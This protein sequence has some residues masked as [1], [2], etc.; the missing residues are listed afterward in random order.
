MFASQSGSALFTAGL[1]VYLNLPLLQVSQMLLSSVTG[2]ALVESVSLTEDTDTH[3][4]SSGLYVCLV[5][6]MYYCYGTC[7][8]II[9]LLVLLHHSCL[10]AEPVNI[11][12]RS[13]CTV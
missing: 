9:Y 2:A 13:R 10:L 8:V 1:T 11:D 4:L 6:Y 12:W 5:V 7:T 3:C